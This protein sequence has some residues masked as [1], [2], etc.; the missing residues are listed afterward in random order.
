MFAIR[1][2]VA[3]AFPDSGEA[4]LVD[5][6]RS[7]ARPFLSLV[8]ELEGEVVGH[9]AFTPLAFDPMS[10]RDR[11]A[12]GLAP[13]SVA[14]AHRRSGIG[15]A[16]VEA[17]IDASREIGADVVVVLGDPGYY[18]RF[19]FEPASSLHLRCAYDA[20][21]EAFQALVLK[22]FEVRPAMT[23]VLFRPEFDAFA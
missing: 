14:P 5:A 21:A 16:L 11:L 7:T 4:S 8:A 6:L 22:A 15:R 2:V 19:G 3:A 12:L 20:P 10:S 9:I 18:A 13:L 17:G 23:S 1:A